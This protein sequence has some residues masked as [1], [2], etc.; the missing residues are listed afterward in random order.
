MNASEIR[1]KS[2]DELAALLLEIR[3][4]QFNLRMQAGMG[5]PARASEIRE[6]RRDVARIKTI[7]QERRRGDA[8]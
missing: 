6:A 7:Q 8:A 2:D 4:K 3:R 1:A 5:Q